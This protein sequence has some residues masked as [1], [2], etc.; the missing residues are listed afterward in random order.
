MAIQAGTLLEC[1]TADGGYAVMR[2]LGPPEQGRDFR[3]VWVCTPDEY[4]RTG[5]NPDGV[6]WP[7]S[8]VRVLEHAQ[9]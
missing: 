8:A 9:G 5:T 4:D 3:V 7:Y 1:E 2:A 6:P